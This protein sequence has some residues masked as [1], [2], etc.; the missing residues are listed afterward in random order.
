MSMHPRLFF[1][2]WP[3]DTV[4]HE[5]LHWQT[6]NLAHNARW[7]HRDDLHMTLDFLGQVEPAR[8][9]GL[10][11]LLAE[12]PGSAF[13]LVLDE[14]GFWPGPQVLWAGPSSVPGALIDLQARLSEGLA[15]L[16]FP[17]E[18]RPYRP[19]VTLARKVGSGSTYGPLAPLTW[20]VSELVLVESRSG[21][22]PR[23]R[24][25]IHRRL[26]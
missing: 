3:D 5:L 14:I 24:P 11:T 17:P 16:G 13:S 8:I 25:L 26:N 15:Q 20:S 9:D 4:R 18:D 22:A 2:L 1:A 10:R 23:Y 7:Q 21:P 6:H 19:H 12:A